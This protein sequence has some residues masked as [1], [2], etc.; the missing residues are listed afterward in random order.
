MAE[1][2]R[3]HTPWRVE[4]APPPDPERA[5]SSPPGRASAC[6]GTRILRGAAAAVRRQ[7]VHRHP[8]QPGE[9]A[10]R[11]ALH[12]LPRPGHPGQRQGDLDQGRHDP[13]QVPDG[14]QTGQDFLQ[15]LRHGPPFLRQR[16][17]ARPPHQQERR[18][19]RP[20]GRRG[21]VVP[22]H[23][24]HLLRLDDPARRPVHP[25][26]APRRGRA[27]GPDRDRPRAREAL[28][29]LAAANDVRGRGG[30][31]RGR[32]RARGDRRLP[33][34]PRKVPTSR[35]DDP[36]G[37]AADEPPGTGKTLLARAVAGEANVP[38]FGPR[39]PSSSR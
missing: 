27:G 30:D 38:F 3:K 36:Q 20:S 10:R 9:D 26:H 6:P 13:G 23:A 2:E 14:G 11:R 19:Q 28:R 5:R 4:G 31:R 1:S 34:G 7:L 15:G 12:D 21:D 39:P 22:R 32:G 35:R 37:G 8:G 16:R 29:R 18:R 25:P 24:A 17:A 33:Q